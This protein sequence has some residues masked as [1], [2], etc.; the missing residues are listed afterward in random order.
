MLETATVAMAHACMYLQ[1]AY[2]EL[3]C[4]VDWNFLNRTMVFEPSRAFNAPGPC[5]CDNVAM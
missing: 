2:G 3:S 1:R 4:Q 5:L